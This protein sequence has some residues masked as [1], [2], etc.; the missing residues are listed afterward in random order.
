MPCIINQP[1]LL[2]LGITE[3]SIPPGRAIRFD[4]DWRTTVRLCNHPPQCGL[5]AGTANR[6]R[7]VPNDSKKDQ[8]PVVVAFAIGT[9]HEVVQPLRK[10]ERVSDAVHTRRQ[11]FGFISIHVGTKSNMR[12]NLSKSSI[13]DRFGQSREPPKLRRSPVSTSSSDFFSRCI[14]APTT[15]QRARARCRSAMP[16]CLITLS[17]ETL[18]TF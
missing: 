2:G 17:H 3:M 11:R 13:K 16:L 14:C 1:S 5:A 10:A 7:A 4:F 18:D 8:T 15:V 6:I 12:A 9:V